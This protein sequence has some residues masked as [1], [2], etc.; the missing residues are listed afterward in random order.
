[1]SQRSERNAEYTMKRHRRLA[2][3]AG[4]AATLTLAQARAASAADIKVLCSN[5]FKAVLEELAPQFERATKHHVVVTY[6]LAATLK[7]RIEAGESF[8]LAILTPAAIDDLVKAGR[9]ASDSRTTLARS[10][11]AIVIRAGAARADIATPDA[12]RRA[13]L[14]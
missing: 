5:G 14:G 4:I 1:S 13:L 9:I 8:D 11:L 3:V 2:V 12:F 6:G 7:Q 10:G